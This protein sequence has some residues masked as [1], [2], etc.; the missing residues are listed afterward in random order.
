MISS[1]PEGALPRVAIL[2]R[3]NVGKSTLFNA[4]IGRR[5][6]ITHSTPGVTRDPVE[7]ECAF[8][9][10]RILLIDTGGFTTDGGELDRL[11]VAKSLET[12]RTADLVLLVL[13]ADGV[14]AADGDFMER[15]RPFSDKLVLVVN[16]VDTPARD[17]GVW[18]F[19]EYGFPTVIGVSA[20]HA[21]NLVELK[22][23]VAAMLGGAG[24]GAG[25]RPIRRHET[26]VRIAILGRPNSG[27]SS[28]SNLLL[29]E[30]K[31]IVS[32]T[33]GTTRDVVEGTF[34]Y[35]SVSFRLL[36]TAGIRRRSRV[37]DSVEFY[38]VSRAVE[39][40]RNA[41][42]VFLMVDSSE[43][44]LDQDKKIAA[45]A[46]DRGR[47]IVLVLS[48]WDLQP[49]EKNRERAAHEAVR[50][51]FPILGFAPVVSVSART[52]AGVKKLLDTALEIK[53]ELDR[54]VGTGRV[55][56]FLREWMSHYPL[57]VRG[58]NVKIRFVTQVSVNPVRF[59]AFVNS[60]AGFPPSYTQYLENCVRRDLGFAMVPVTVE[61]RKSGK[62]E[63]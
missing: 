43:G 58:R 41:D 45:Y 38:S 15:L 16:K 3:P 24:E 6:A 32:P 35:R 52:G 51:Q 55:N 25:I 48:K 34:S 11:V 26:G 37:K 59:I 18:N 31:S 2:G 13:E 14:T 12:A 21:R 50:F 19:H 1:P 29:G 40:V 10:R 46:V 36:D 33:A 4:L 8:A 17:H 22:E 42:I 49:K 53:K 47:G 63:R 62:V 39:S 61:L 28:L 27:K 9:D 54:R 23:M 60:L 5:R 20:A 7:S 44:L 30:E 56:K 57:P